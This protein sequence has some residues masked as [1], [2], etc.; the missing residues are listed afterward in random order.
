MS[1]LPHFLG[2]VSLGRTGHSWWI[3]GMVTPAVL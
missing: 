2:K 1:S 3:I